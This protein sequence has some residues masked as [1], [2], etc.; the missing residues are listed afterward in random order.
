M[1]SQ[2]QRNLA[3]SV[4]AVIRGQLRQMDMLAR[5]GGDEFVAVMPGAN[6]D[7]AAVV[8]ERVRAAVESHDFTVRT[9]RTVRVGV[10]FGVGC[11]PEEVTA[12]DLLLAATRNMQRNKHARKPSPRPASVVSIDAYR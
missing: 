1:D 5:Y 10:S 2:T 11:Y 8:A 9:G 3:A 6:G 7:A 4:A 12:D